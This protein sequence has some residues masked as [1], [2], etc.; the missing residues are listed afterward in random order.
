M[1]ITV[2]PYASLAYPVVIGFALAILG[3]GIFLNKSF[4]LGILI[5]VISAFCI[6]VPVDKALMGVTEKPLKKIAIGA[7]Y[8]QL[9]LAIPDTRIIKIE[10]NLE[11]KNGEIYK[12][13]PVE[14]SARAVSK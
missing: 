2:V 7:G 10:V 3:T 9:I 12:I 11:L 13:V 4:L 1:S 14:G 5:L 8:K 6:F